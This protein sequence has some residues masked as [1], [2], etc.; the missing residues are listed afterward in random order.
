MLIPVLPPIDE[1]T[2]AKSVVGIF[3]NLIPLLKI[4]EANPETSP[5][6]PP[7]I[8]IKQSFL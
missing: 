5:T 1:S 6:I 7:P 4:L 8:D 3:I 2:C